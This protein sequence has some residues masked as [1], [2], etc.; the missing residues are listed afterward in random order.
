MINPIKNAVPNSSFN[1]SRFNIFSLFLGLS[2]I[3]S[4]DVGF[5]PKVNA[6]K[7]SVTRFINSICIETRRGV[8]HP[9]NGANNTPKNKVINYAKLQ[10]SWYVTNF[11]ILLYTVLPSAIADIIVAKLSSFNIRSEAERDT[12][13][14]FLPIAIPT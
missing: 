11:L 5:T 14:P 6:G 3:I 7:L 4:F 13:V 10:L 12:S 1:N 9:N 2:S 8:C